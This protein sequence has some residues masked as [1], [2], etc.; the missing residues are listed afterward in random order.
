MKFF[1][2]PLINVADF[3]ATNA[4]ILLRFEAYDI[5][6]M[7]GAIRKYPYTDLGVPN[8]EILLRFFAQKMPLKNET[9]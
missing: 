4:W 7:F 6:R 8:L 5:L 9:W 1:M 2:F 3:R